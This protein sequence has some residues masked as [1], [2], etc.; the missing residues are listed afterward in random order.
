MCLR[1]CFGH[2]DDVPI[3]HEAGQ[4]L[5]KGFKT[6]EDNTFAWRHHD[7]V[8]VREHRINGDGLDSVFRA[9]HVLKPARTFGITAA[10][11]MTDEDSSAKNKDVAAFEIAPTLALSFVIRA[12][13][14]PSA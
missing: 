9:K 2:L 1:E 3:G 4:A 8:Q 10:A 6:G 5:G 7:T 12:I 13:G 14:C 11:G